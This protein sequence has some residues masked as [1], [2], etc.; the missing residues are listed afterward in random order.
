MEP[1][2][3]IGRQL[4]VRGS[5][6]RPSRI[7]G[8]PRPEGPRERAAPPRT[9]AACDSGGAGRPG[10]SDPGD[11]LCICAQGYYP[12]CAFKNASTP[13]DRPRTRDMTRHGTA[14][15]PDRDR[16]RGPP[17][18]SPWPCPPS[19][20]RP[21]GGAVAGAASAPPRRSRPPTQCRTHTLSAP[22]VPRPGLRTAWACPPP[23][24]RPVSG[25]R[26]RLRTQLGQARGRTFWRARVARGR[27]LLYSKAN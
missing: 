10:R 17:S 1:L 18:P 4:P 20:G 23:T 13:R 8:G 5:R 22:R 26:R 3:S 16:A 7:C 21:G 24:S 9:S 12:H 25:G 6:S 2:L 14:T 11:P 27:Y 19:P 15:A